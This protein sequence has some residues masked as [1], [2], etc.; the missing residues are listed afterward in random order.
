MW[1][2]L[3]GPASISIADS[4]I[5]N[6]SFTEEVSSG[7]SSCYGEV[8]DPDCEVCDSALQRCV[9]RSCF[10]IEVPASCRCPELSAGTLVAVGAVLLF[11]LLLL[12]TMAVWHWG[13]CGD[14]RTTLTDATEGLLQNQGGAMAPEANFFAPRASR[15]GRTSID[16]CVSCV[17]CMDG[18]INCVLSTPTERRILA[19]PSCLG[20]WRSPAHLESRGAT[21]PCAHE[22]ACHRCA[23]RL[24]LC[25]ICR[26]A[27]DS[28]LRIFP[29]E[30][31]DRERAL[32]QPVAALAG[33]PSSEQPTPSAVPTATAGAAIAEEP[34][35][36]EA[37]GEAA[38]DGAPPKVG[39]S[40]PTMLCLRCAA[41]PP[42]CVFLPCS[43]KV[44]C[45]ECAAQLPPECPI[46]HSGISQSLKTFHKRL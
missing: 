2:P 7:T 29:A 18:A 20:T 27:V 25:P 26:R 46:C 3:S 10:S 39:S 41:S 45:V 22:V 6:V 11:L 35:D 24:A 16:S 37:G 5:S 40:L 9:G 19:P 30:A 34:G 13:R 23:T 1:L 31:V 38:V 33:A 28:T 21:V 36:D 42:N 43:H 8:C 32:Q 12:L 44:W 4:S 14:R 15:C 17:V